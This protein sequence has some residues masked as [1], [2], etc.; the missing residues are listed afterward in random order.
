MNS[1]FNLCIVPI[2]STHL[3]EKHMITEKRILVK[4]IQAS[5][6]CSPSFSIT[7]KDMNNSMLDL[8]GYSRQVKHITTTL[9]TFYLEIGA[10]VLR[11][12][13]YF[14]FFEKKPVSLSMADRNAKRQN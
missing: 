2:R 8:I 14:L 4:S 11:I 6:T 1:V 9:G 3:M 12:C 13:F 5:I 7:R 10:M